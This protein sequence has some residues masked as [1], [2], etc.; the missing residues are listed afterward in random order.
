MNSSVCS[1]N[2]TPLGR[3]Q[4]PPQQVPVWKKYTL[5]IEEAAAYFR[6]GESKLRRMISE[7]AD[8]DFILWNGNRAQI[9]R[10]KFEEYIDKCQAI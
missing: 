9:K 2:D 10:K 6:I 8:A 5:T 3:E 1:V 7:D 4:I